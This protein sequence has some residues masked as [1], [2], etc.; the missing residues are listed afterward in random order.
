[1]SFCTAINCMDG[2]TQLPVIDYLQTELDVLYVDTI[3]EAGPLRL[4]FGD[5]ASEALQSIHA[6]IAVSRQAHGSRALALVAH[7]LC[8]G[9]PVDDALQQQQLVEAS[10][11]L[12]RKYPDMLVIGLWVNDHW[13]VTRVCRHDPTVESETS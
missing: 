1:M 9:H 5:E 13:A 12:S 2:R 10:V 8:A 4:F 7:A 3:T 6:R 11:L